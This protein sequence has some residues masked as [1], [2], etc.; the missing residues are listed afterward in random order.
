MSTFN[1]PSECTF[2]TTRVGS[3]KCLLPFQFV[4]D[5]TLPEGS[6]NAIMEI[7][8]IHATYGIQNLINN[9]ELSSWFPKHQSDDAKSSK[10]QASFAGNFEITFKTTKSKLSNVSYSEHGSQTDSITGSV[11]EYTSQMSGARVSTKSNTQS[12]DKKIETWAELVQE[13]IDSKSADSDIRKEE[14][15]SKASL[16]PQSMRLGKE[17]A[18]QEL[19]QAQQRHLIQDL[20]MAI[21]CAYTIHQKMRSSIKLDKLF[22]ALNYEINLKSTKG[23]S[24][25]PSFSTTLDGE[26]ALSKEII[27]KHTSEQ[28]LNWEN[29]SKEPKT[30]TCLLSFKELQ[31]SNPN[32]ST[33]KL[34]DVLLTFFD[35]IRNT[36]EIS[37]DQRLMI[38]NS[39]SFELMREGNDKA[40]DWSV[41]TLKVKSKSTIKQQIHKPVEIGQPIILGKKGGSLPYPAINEQFTL[42]IEQQLQL[43]VNKVVQKKGVPLPTMIADM[44]VEKYFF[45]LAAEFIRRN[46]G[47]RNNNSFTSPNHLTK[48]IEYTELPLDNYESYATYVVLKQIIDEARERFKATNTQASSLE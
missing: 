27:A 31:I 20:I 18:P 8:E 47:W 25:R 38:L 43:V 41:N 14:V 3:T 6:L 4:S 15:K 30:C 42:F 17:T 9:K 29:G 1:Y 5:F 16:V 11:Y 2:C 45:K 40:Y 13:S 22:S 46:K 12:P 33:I 28:V 24:Y 36:S 7:T 10:S 34:E 21:K 44:K 26:I 48:V 37:N 39:T 35:L 23:S 19:E 32:S